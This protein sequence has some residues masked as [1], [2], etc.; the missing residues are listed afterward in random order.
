MRHQLVKPG[1]VLAGLSIAVG[2]LAACSSNSS[3]ASSGPATSASGSAGS[4]SSS[5]AKLSGAPIKL[6]VIAPVNSV[7]ESEPYILQ[8]AK[9]GAAA[10]NAAGGIMGRPVEIDFCDDMFTPQGGALCAQKLLVQDKDLMLV[11]SGGEE[12]TAVVPVLNATNTI[13]FG[14]F[15]GGAA[16]NTS[17]RVYMWTPQLADGWNLWRVVPSSTKHIDYVTADEQYAQEGI[18]SVQAF[19]PKNYQ[20]STTLIPLTAVSMQPSCINIKDTGADTVMIETAAGQAASIMQTCLQLGLRNVTWVNTSIILS[21]S[22][23]QTVTNLHLT[24]VVEM[25]YSGSTLREFAAD[26]AKY[27]PQVGGISNAVVDESVN[28]W[29]SVKLLPEV[30]SHVGSLDPTKIKAWLDQQTAFSTDGALP[31]LNFAA[32]PNSELPREKDLCAYAGKIEN[33]QLVQT[34]SAPFCTPLAEAQ[35]WR[36]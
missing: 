21:P 2:L 35:S 25:A 12:D 10:V 8:A 24:D 36:G 32:N 34:S 28:A 33:D 15:G 9:I 26:V 17:P 14:D 1:R 20:F 23:M 27:G 29:L 7:I 22:F 11:G 31:P 5:T 30:I 6:G 19:M 3:K 4:T 18:R 13:S 16:S